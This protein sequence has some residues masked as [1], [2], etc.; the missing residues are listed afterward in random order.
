LISVII[1]TYN[2]E[3]FIT[4]AIDSVLKQ[5]FSD[6]EIVV[7]DDGSTDNTREVLIP[8]SNKIKYIYQRNSGVSSARNTAIQAAQGLWISFLDS[9]DEWKKEYLAVQMEQIKKYPMAVGHITN[10]ETV[11]MSGER[12]EH[13]EETGLVKKY[14]GLSTLFIERPLRTIVRYS[15]WFL[16]S[17]VFRKDILLATRL[18]D[19]ELSIAEDLDVIT[20]MAMKGP[21]TFCNAIMVEVYR[22]KEKIEN[23]GEQSKKNDLIRYQS[24]LKAYENMLYFPTLTMSEKITV[25]RYLGIYLRSVGNVLFAEGKR[26]FSRTLFRNALISFP[27]IR[28]FVKILLTYIPN[29]ILN[30]LGVNKKSI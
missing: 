7:V 13:F 22:R 8:Y 18:F 9:D 11:L 6:Y 24:F 25:K 3:R 29:R 28:T 21:F 12:S 19:L 27:S 4:K 14:R 16:Q 2:R 5:R 15:P 26:D 30:I 17:T 20:Q 23:L 1:P 10:A